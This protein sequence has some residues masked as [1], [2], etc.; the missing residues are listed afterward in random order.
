MEIRQF[1]EKRIL[2]QNE[3]DRLNKLLDKSKFEIDE[4]K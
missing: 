1:E 2:L 3:I 4:L